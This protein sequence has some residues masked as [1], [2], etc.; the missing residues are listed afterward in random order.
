MKRREFVALGGLAA[1]VAAS[2]LLDCAA[3]EL[4]DAAA[5]ETKGVK[6]R[7]D[8]DGTITEVRVGPDATLTLD[9]YRS[10]G[11]LRNTL[12]RVNIS[13]KQPRLNGEILAAIGPLPRVEQ[14]FSNGAKLLDDDFQHFVQ[15][16]S[17]QRFGL[18]HWGWFE[19]P[20]KKF[21]GPG[22]AHLAELPKLE[23]LRLGGCRIEN[24][25]VE[26]IAKIKSLQYAD[27]FH[28]QITDDGIVHLRNLPNLRVIKLGP[29]FAPRITDSSLKYLAGIPTLEEIH[30]SETWLTYSHGFV[31][32]KQLPKLRLVVLKEVLATAE[33]VATLKADHPHA[34]VQWTEPDAADVKKMKA[35]FERHRTKQSEERQR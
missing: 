32:L 23:W 28:D 31:H 7:K 25:A 17:L 35:R 27:L 10:I 24:P 11:E 13:P 33:D 21:V 18:D 5:L 16:T 4:S 15:W 19:T 3:V 20:D 9:D 8:R 2:P 1:A 6:F 22:L 14:F 26:A 29:Q 30:Y 34:E 12:R